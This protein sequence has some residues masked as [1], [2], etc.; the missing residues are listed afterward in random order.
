MAKF[1]FNATTPTYKYHNRWL[2]TRSFFS[3]SFSFSFTYFR[4]F[5]F[6]IYIWNQQTSKNLT[7][8]NGLNTNTYHLPRLPFTN[9]NHIDPFLFLNP[10]SLSIDELPSPFPLPLTSTHTN[11]GGSGAASGGVAG[12]INWP[13]NGGRGRAK[14]AGWP[15][16]SIREFRQGFVVLEYDEG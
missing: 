15:R 10:H 3:L 2:Y 14:G 4:F 5:S 11:N 16:T 13:S 1:K 9:A 8:L 7:G 6:F 12:S